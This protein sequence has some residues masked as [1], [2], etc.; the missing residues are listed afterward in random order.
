MKTLRRVWDWWKDT[1]SFA[2]LDR[3]SRKDPRLAY[4][5]GS[6]LWSAWM[7]LFAWYFL[8]RR[9]RIYEKGSFAEQSWQSRCVFGAVL[10]IAAVVP[11]AFKVDP[12]NGNSFEFRWRALTNLRNRLWPEPAAKPRGRRQGP[13]RRKTRG[14]RGQGV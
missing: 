10:L 4:T 3:I 13:S 8:D 6:L 14:N 5:I 7:C 12:E 9:I 2:W 1:I 11:L